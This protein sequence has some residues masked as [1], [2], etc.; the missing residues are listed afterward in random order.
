M[1]LPNYRITDLTSF[2]EATKEP[3][4]IAGLYFYQVFDVLVDVAYMVSADFRKRP[5]LYRDLGQPSIAPT[6][7]KLNAQYG[8]EIDNLSATQRNEVYLPLFGA[9]DTS[10]PYDNESFPCLRDDLIRTA[11]A[12]AERAVDTGISMLRESVRTSHRLFK[13][14]LLSLHGDSVRFSKEKAL[15]EMTEKICYPILRNHGVAAVFGI[16]KNAS[17]EYPYAT[18]PAEDLLLEQISTQLMP[19][20]AMRA[21]LTRERVSNLQRAALRGA[22]AIATAIDYDE[23]HHDHTDAELDLLISKCYTWGTALASLKVRTTSVASAT[24]RL[25]VS[26][27]RLQGIA[28]TRPPRP[29]PS[30]LTPA[31]LSRPTIPDPI[32]STLGSG[33]WKPTIEYRRALAPE[34]WPTALRNR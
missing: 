2:S 12:F 15:S 30:A 10:P 5:Q 8:T 9:F 34:R 13:D 33:F 16:A 23:T 24:G 21:L 25:A 32:V 14:Y 31:P 18:D 1:S 22:E 17:I 29:Q 20:G 26:E 4:Q 7:G 11:T 28:S 6:L 27:S 3:R 19:S